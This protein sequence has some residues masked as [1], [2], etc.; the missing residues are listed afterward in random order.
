MAF[1][2]SNDSRCMNRKKLVVFLLWAFLPMIA[3]GLAMH[4]SGA[5]AIEGAADATGGES[6]TAIKH[7]VFSAGAMLIPLLAVILT[8]LIFKEL[9]LKGVGISFKVN[10]WWWIGW[11]LMPVIAIASLGVSLLMPEARWTPDS[12]MVQ[13]SMQSMP[14]GV[15][16][17]GL[18]GIT[19]LSGLFAGITINAVF[20]FG[21]EIAWRGFLMKEFKGK[22]FLSVVLWIGVIWGLWHAPIILNGHNYPQHPVVGVFMMVVFCILLTVMLM[23]FREKSGSVIV[24]AIMHGTF[25]A[26]AGVTAAVVTPANDLLYGAAGL[27][28]MIVLLVVDVCLY[29]YDKYV[30]K[31]N[32]FST[33]L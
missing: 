20:A 14:E 30:S 18:I 24:A 16:V 9:V 4:I 12:E 26:V 2:K 6:L 5:S 25:N 13:Q 10:K 7:L 15:G 27:A 21:E 33:L 1:A 29:L 23:Y 22:K 19:L 3:V 28:G 17:W 8:Q 11:L 31:E 32:I